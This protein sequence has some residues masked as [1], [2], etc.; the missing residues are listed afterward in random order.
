MLNK[1][2]IDGQDGENVC[3]MVDLCGEKESWP[4][5]KKIFRVSIIV[6]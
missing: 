3:K 4:M 6:K 1:G 2:G 5:F